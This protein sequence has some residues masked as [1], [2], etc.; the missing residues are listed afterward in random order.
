MDR[1]LVIAHRGASGREAENS[2][3]AFRIARELG[4][5]GVELDVH[6]TADGHLVVHHDEMIGHHHIAHCSLA[7]VQSHHLKN[8]ESIPT[9]AQALDVIVPAMIAFIEIK[10]LAPKWDQRFFDRLDR[11]PH[12]ERIAIHSFDHRIIHRLGD[13][14]PHLARGVLSSSYPV[15]PARMMEDADASALWQHA[16]LIDRALVEKVHAAGGVVYAWTVDQPEAME[17]LLALGVDGL[18]TN[19]PDRARQAVDSLT[20]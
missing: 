20:S 18:C 6:A 11:Y 15:H 14:R 16:P 1:P 5:D 12:V 19:H 3:A 8:G 10:A 13:E 4:A 7:E 2:L 17:K 9:L